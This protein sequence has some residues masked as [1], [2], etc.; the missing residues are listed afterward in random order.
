M[1]QKKKLVVLLAAAMLV[2]ACGGG[3]GGGGD[4]GST[5]A[6]G[7]AQPAS[8]AAQSG[9]GSTS[10]ANTGGGT[11]SPGTGGGATIPP[12]TAGGGNT[13]P[14]NPAPGTD[15]PAVPSVAADPQMRGYLEMVGNQ[16]NYLHQNREVYWALLLEDFVGDGVSNAARG[17]RDGREPGWIRPPAFAP[18]APLASFGIRVNRY[19]QPSTSGEAVGGQTVVGRVAFDLTER[20]APAGQTA[21]IMRLVID[22]VELSTAANG[23]LTTARVRDGGQMHIYGRNAAGVEVRDTIPVPAAAVRL[24]PVS[25]ILDHY[26]DTSSIVVLVDFEQAFSQAGSRLAALENMAGDFSLGI[27]MSSAKL[28]RPASAN[29]ERGPL[30]RKDMAGPR[31]TVDNQ[32][33]VTGGGL[34]GRAHL[35]PPQ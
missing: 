3:G 26:G 20:S 34:S 22:G 30:E 2:A 11:T 21:E 12:A 5:A 8:T 23:E 28:V 19:M 31:I 32:P 6:S 7:N 25:E 17:S 10:S 1:F 13:S 16:V 35:T 14:N 4:N 15:Q 29:Y 24:L 18:A 27:T 33:A 9:T